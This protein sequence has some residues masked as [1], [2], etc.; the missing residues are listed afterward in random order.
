MILFPL[1]SL[2]R[3]MYYRYTRT[4]ERINISATESNKINQAAEERRS[5]TNGKYREKEEAGTAM[6][7]AASPAPG[8][9]P[10]ARPPPYIFLFSRLLARPQQK[11]TRRYR[12]VEEHRRRLSKYATCIFA[13]SLLLGLRSFASG[14]CN[15]SLFV[16][17]NCIIIIS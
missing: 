11:T 17:D 12:A 7:P 5:S 16:I 9:P 10:P 1:P 8:R 13:N 4:F 2:I 15:Y 3:N 14:E 6:Q